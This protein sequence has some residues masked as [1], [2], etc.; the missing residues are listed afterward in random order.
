[1]PKPYS[2][3]LRIKAISL[4]NSGQKIEQVAILLSISSNTRRNWLCLR[5][6]TKSLSPKVGYQKG[7]SHKIKDLEAFKMFVEKHRG[8]TLE[9]MAQ[10]WGNVSD[11]TLGR[12]MKKIGYTHKKRLLAIK[13]EMKKQETYFSQK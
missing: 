8:K 11:T 13:K 12:M 6:K 4:I 7:H 2:T 3:D 5:E 9:M 10:E 1:M